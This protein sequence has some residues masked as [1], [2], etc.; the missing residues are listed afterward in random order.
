MAH[1]LRQKS[2]V[3]VAFG[4]CAYEGCI[5]AL[6]NLTTAEA[7]FQTVYLNSL[8]TD[9]PDRI[10]PQTITQVPEGELEIPSFYNTVKSLDQVVAVD[11]YLPGCPPEPHQIW[12]VLEVVV[13]A[14]LQGAELPPAGSIVGAKD[15]GCLRGMSTGKE[16]EADRPL[17][18][19]LR[20]RP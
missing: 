2:K 7:T 5:P 11:Y 20:D 17:L 12:A 9:N 1:L 4:S 14:L 19:P 8:S 13:A 18:P 10:T 3:L 15:G 6:S 16:R